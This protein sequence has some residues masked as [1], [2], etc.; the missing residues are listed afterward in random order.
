M[1]NNNSPV[2]PLRRNTSFIK[3]LFFIILFF[4]LAGGLLYFIYQNYSLKKQISTNQKKLAKLLVTP[5]PDPTQQIT[6]K[7][8]K[9][10]DADWSVQYPSKADCAYGN[11]W[12]VETI[13]DRV[14]STNGSI[15]VNGKY[16]VPANPKINSI[17]YRFDDTIHKNT[18]FTLIDNYD[19]SVSAKFDYIIIGRTYDDYS[20]LEKTTFANHEAYTTLEKGGVI[21]LTLVQRG[22]HVYEFR[23]IE[24]NDISKQMLSTFKF[25]E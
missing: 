14:M 19:I 16:Y 25:T 24:S 17:I 20:P 5:S 9:H 12:Y 3:T 4:L 13:Y 7:T 10:S 2:L 22:N 21:R 6:W 15:K 11:P 1:E 18:P 23:T 8:F